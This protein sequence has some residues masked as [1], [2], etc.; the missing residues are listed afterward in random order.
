[1]SE[2]YETVNEYHEEPVKSFDAY[3]SIYVCGKNIF[4]SMQERTCAATGSIKE[5]SMSFIEDISNLNRTLNTCGIIL[6]TLNYQKGALQILPSI[7]L[8]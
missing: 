7:V 3:I 5:V 2:K 6:R 8:V 1:M 4:H